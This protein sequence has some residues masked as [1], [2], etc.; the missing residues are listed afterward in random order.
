MNNMKNAMLSKYLKLCLLAVTLILICGCSGNSSDRNGLVGL[1]VDTDNIG[2]EFTSSGNL[3]IVEGCDSYA[4]TADSL[5]IYDGSTVT[6]E[7][8]RTSGE[9]SGLEGSWTDESTGNTIS[10]TQSNFLS[11]TDG[12]VSSGSY[13]IIGESIYLAHDAGYSYSCTVDTLTIYL[14]GNPEASGSYS[15]NGD[16]L[17]LDGWQL[18]RV[19]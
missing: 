15:I 6:I 7:Y 10:F 13:Y 5:T 3:Y 18:Y 9:G 19:F 1:W 11:D 16:M 17:D 8:S 2:F 12:N 14:N 4:V